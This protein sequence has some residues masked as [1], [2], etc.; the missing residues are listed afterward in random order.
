MEFP[1]LSATYLHLALEHNL[2]QPCA[3]LGYVFFPL[4]FDILYD[5]NYDTWLLSQQNPHHLIVLK[6]LHLPSIPHTCLY[7]F[8]SFAF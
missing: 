3:S 5:S 2:N 4:L 6:G 1:D 7:I 8:Q